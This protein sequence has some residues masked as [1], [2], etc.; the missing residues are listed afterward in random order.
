MSMTSACVCLLFHGAVAVSGARP[1]VSDASRAGGDAVTD[2]DVGVDAR[3]P[4]DGG[5][6]RAITVASAVAVKLYGQ[7]AGLEVGYGSGILVSADGLVL[8]VYSLLIDARVVRATIADGTRYE[9]DVV[10]H[11]KP[12]QL[13]L[14]R[15]RR[16]RRVD[17]LGEPVA[18]S[19][20]PLPTLAFADLTVTTKLQRGDWIIAAGNP[21]RVANGAE[22]VSIAHGVF[23]LRTRLDAKRR[24]R[25]FP[26]HGDVLV[27]DAI[28]SNPGAPG[29]VVVDLDGRLVGMIG[30]EV[31][32]NQTNTHFN[33]AIPRDVLHGFFLE[34]TG[35]SPTDGASSGSS[36]RET[37]GAFDTGIRLS[38]AG[39][40]TVLPFVERVRR[41]S[42][43]GLAG[44]RQDDLIMSVNGTNVTVVAEYEK[45]LETLPVSESIDLVIRRGRRIMTIRI[46][47][48][49]EVGE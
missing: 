5:F 26:Y 45:R 23:C 22:P 17:A 10:A 25:D 37:W 31:T 44:V 12:R 21:F 9:A 24:L 42:P 3:S 41:Q 29:S 40:R 43:A 6:D 15:L 30:R 49:K 14:L 27:I 20:N 18:D 19:D 36:D 38:R 34:A 13:A 11:D 16:P 1:S 35:Q 48:P 4:T 46:E 39:Y 47:P 33:Y 8:T 32:S 28:T 2:V 7:G